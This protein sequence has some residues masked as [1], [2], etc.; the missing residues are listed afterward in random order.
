VGLTALLVLTF[1]I[2]RTWTGRALRATAQDADAAAQMGVDVA[3]ARQL[4]FAM[5]GGIGALAGVLAAFY[6]QSVFPQMGLPFGLKGFAA[7]VLGGISSL[8]GA[9]A[10]GLL[11]GMMETLAS[12]YLGESYRDAV[13]YSLLLLLLVFRPAG[14]FGD[15]RLEALGGAGAAGGAMPSTSLL[16][17]GSSAR[18]R[19]RVLEL[20]AWGILL[21]GVLLAA[22][23]LL[24]DS[25]YVI[26]AASGGLIFALLAVSVTLA[27]GAAGVLSIG[28]AAFYGVGAYIAAIAA[29]TYGW[30]AEAVLPAAGL[31]A[32]VAAAVAAVPLLRLSGHTVALGTL[33][34]GQIGA[35]VFLNWL[36]VTRGPMGIPGIPQAW[37]ASLDQLRLSGP[38]AKYYGILAVA[39]LGIALASRL[40]ASPLGRIWRAIREDRLAAVAA[41][42]PVNRYI[43]LAFAASGFLA[44]LAG[45]LFAYL[46]T[47]VSPESFTVETSVLLLIMAVLGGLGN[48]TGAMVTGFA[49]A[50]L[51]E[52]LRDFEDFRMIVYGLLLLVMLRLRPQG[53]FGAR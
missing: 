45:A 12:G 19:I 46:Q 20:P 5:S 31:G 50:V 42:V 10:G 38:V 28:H 17:E 9:V 13:A 6:F 3:R 41:G 14:L 2:S 34:V 25:R 30:P 48:V 37:L 22:L 24:N 15:R 43:V 32:A 4:A 52:F 23:P 21:V 7:A 39:I 26:Q 18:A 40:V 51:P 27:S 33:A 35:L 47:V 16:A 11:L 1:V 44:G 53:L 36:S 8:P 49:L 29:K